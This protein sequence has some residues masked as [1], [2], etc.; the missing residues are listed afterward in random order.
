[1]AVHIFRRSAVYYWRRRVKLATSEV[2]ARVRAQG[3]RL[4]EGLRRAADGLR[5]P[6]QVTGEGPCAGIHFTREDVVDADIAERGNQDLW[7]LMCLGVTNQG[8]AITSRT[9]GPIAPY[10]GED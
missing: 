4:R 6:V 8:L 5:I 1:M 9:F 10:I 2:F 3:A 7:R